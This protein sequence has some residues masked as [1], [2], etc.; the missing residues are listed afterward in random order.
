[1]GVN[2]LGLAHRASVRFGAPFCIWR[3]LPLCS[4]GVTRVP[5]DFYFY[6]ESD[7]GSDCDSDCEWDWDWDLYCNSTTSDFSARRSSLKRI[8]QNEAAF[9]SP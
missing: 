1:M 4:L 3:R 8:M 5:S 9:E 2:L 6:S 7:S